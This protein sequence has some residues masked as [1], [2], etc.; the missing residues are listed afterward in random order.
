M[1]TYLDETQKLRVEHDTRHCHRI[2]DS[3]ADL[4][5]GT[6]ICKQSC[7]GYYLLCWLFG[8]FISRQL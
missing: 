5:L 3:R 8:C 2:Y 1:S 4:M 6:V 7:S